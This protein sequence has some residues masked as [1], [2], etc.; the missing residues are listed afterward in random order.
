MKRMAMLKK[1]LYIGLFFAAMAYSEEI[2][3]VTKM[4]EACSR[5]MKGACYELG[6]LYEQGLRVEQNITTSMKYY[7]KAC[8]LGY[9]KACQSLDRLQSNNA[10]K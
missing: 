2:K 9:E 1:L 3:E 7:D 5:E 4:K 6:M 8:R 10:I